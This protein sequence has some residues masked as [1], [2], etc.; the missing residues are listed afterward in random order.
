MTSIGGDAFNGCSSSFTVVFESGSQ[1]QTIGEEAFSHSGLSGTITFPPSLTS[2]G[3]LGFG[4]SPGLR[5][6]I[7]SCS[8]SSI[9]IG[10]LSFSGTSVSSISLPDGATCVLSNCGA[11]VNQL[12]CNPTTARSCSLVGMLRKCCWTQSE[13]E[14]WRTWCRD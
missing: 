6:A 10:Y 12:N 4:N 14:N 13:P 7:F 1:L 11:T 2:I 5:W 3:E 8:S 9:V